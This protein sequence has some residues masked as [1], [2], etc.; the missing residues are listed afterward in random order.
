MSIAQP[1]TLPAD[2]IDGIERR[3][4]PRGIPAEADPDDGADDEARDR[5]EPRKDHG[6]VEPE[7]D[8]I[9]PGNA[10]K[11]SCEAAGLGQNDRLEKKL[12]DDVVLSRADRFAHPDL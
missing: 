2:C 1:P 7:C 3:R 12:F 6:D 11:N 8:A 10:E 9:S 4:F 5:P